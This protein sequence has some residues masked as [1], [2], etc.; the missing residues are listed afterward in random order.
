MTKS[1]SQSLTWDSLAPAAIIAVVVAVWFK[2]VQDVVSAPYLV[3]TLSGKGV[4]I[5]D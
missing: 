4:H 5:F 2:L 3:R 1:S